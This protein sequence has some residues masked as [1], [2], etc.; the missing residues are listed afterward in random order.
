MRA[1]SLNFVD[2]AVV[3]GLFHGVEYPVT[4]V[5][6]GA[7]EVM[8]VGAGVRGLAPGDRVAVHPKAAW[9]AGPG[10]AQQQQI[11]RGV[12][13]P[14]SLIEIATVDAASLVKAPDHLSWAEIAA[15]PICA[16]TAWN[17]M[18]AGGVGPASTV[19]LLGT[20]GVSTLAL[21]L[22]KASG[23]RVILTSSSDAK[24]ERARELGADAVIN[25]RARPDWDAAVLELT[26]GTGADLLVET[27]GAETFARSLG[28]LRQGG[29]VFTVGFVTGGAAQVDLMTI[30][31][32]ALRVM[33]NNT[34]SVADLAEA[35]AVIGQ[36]AV[37]PPVA[38]TFG[39]GE[40]RE[41]Y[42]AQGLAAH[43][44]KLGIVLDW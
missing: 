5:A 15:L 1:A 2:L 37:R 35:M 9:I 8:A 18:K 10:D 23:A 28:A 30:I 34:G 40:V 13:L 43:V 21:Q 7:G 38:R 16:T 3:R 29:T 39:L 31:V 42:E 44:G 20:G 4:P 19:V 17:A 6:D 26:G 41:A 25:Y 24:L 22:A 27:V 32:K 12:S 11:M 33:G 36:H 14:G